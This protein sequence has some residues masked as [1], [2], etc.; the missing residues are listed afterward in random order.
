MIPRP[1]RITEEDVPQPDDRHRALLMSKRQALI[2]ELGA[3][4]DYLEMERS[5]IPRRKRPEEIARKFD[6]LT[7]GR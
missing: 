3:I 5:I 7:A 4:E 2:I 1:I 6:A